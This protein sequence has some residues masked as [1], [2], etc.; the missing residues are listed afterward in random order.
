MVRNRV[1]I[2]LMIPPLVFLHN[3]QRRLWITLR[4]HFIP[5]MIPGDQGGF[6]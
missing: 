2:E 4:Y 5:M 6:P 1:L 3:S